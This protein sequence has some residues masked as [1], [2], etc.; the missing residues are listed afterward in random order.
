[1]GTWGRPCPGMAPLFPFLKGMVQTEGR[2]TYCV[3]ADLLPS[4]SPAPGTTMALSPTAMPRRPLPLLRVGTSCGARMSSPST[5]ASV[6]AGSSA[7]GTM[8]TWVSRGSPQVAGWG[9]PGSSLLPRS[10]GV[11]I[12]GVSQAWLGRAMSRDSPALRGGWMGAPCPSSAVMEARPGPPSAQ[13]W[14]W[15]LPREARWEGVAAGMARTV[16][17]SPW[18]KAAFL[19]VF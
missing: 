17:V 8:P 13:L 4:P 16:P 11:P 15:R 2:Q 19:H 12:L 18:L 5:C 3:A 6:A 1:M 9:D 10:T 7:G 14:I